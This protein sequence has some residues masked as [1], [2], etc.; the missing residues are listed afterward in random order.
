MANA[1]FSNLLETAI[2]ANFTLSFV[3]NS[4]KKVSTT[5]I[6]LAGSKRTQE[7]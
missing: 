2:M 5:F 4:L 1:C 6:L 7:Q 3:C